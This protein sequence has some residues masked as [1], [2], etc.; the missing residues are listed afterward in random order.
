[1]LHFDV[2]LLEMPCSPHALS[3][4]TAISAG[5]ALHTVVILVIISS[6]TN[7]AP[8]PCST[9]LASA[10]WRCK[11]MAS[12]CAM[13]SACPTEQ[14]GSAVSSLRLQVQ[15]GIN[16]QRLRFRQHLDNEMAH[17]AEDCW[18]AEIDSTYGWVE[19]V[20]LADRSAFDL[21]VRDSHPCMSCTVHCVHGDYREDRAELHICG[22]KGILWS[23]LLSKY[24]SAYGGAQA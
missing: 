12:L 16:P 17:Y 7:P 15:V 23:H 19:C 14:C 4:C 5:T 8:G 21:R 10:D 11:G 22:S 20:G 13:T 2:L 9:P 18:D 24:L 3:F 6:G 1:M